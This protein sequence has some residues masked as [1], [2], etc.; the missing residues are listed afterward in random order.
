MGWAWASY[1][2]AAMATKY[3]IP[4]GRLRDS[5]KDTKERGKE[6]G[7]MGAHICS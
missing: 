7:A 4:R 1:A 2:A 3:V 6:M 5:G